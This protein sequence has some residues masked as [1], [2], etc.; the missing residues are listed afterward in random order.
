MGINPKGGFWNAV[1]NWHEIKDCCPYI[2]IEQGLLCFKVGEI[3]ERQ[4]ETRDHYH[5]LFM[6]HCVD[7]REIRRPN[8]FGKGVYMT[9]AVVDRVN[10]LGEDDGL[11]D[12]NNVVARLAYFES[13]Y[14][15]MIEK[16]RFDDTT[17]SISRS[18]A[19]QP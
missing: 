5:E 17:A 2:Q 9:I 4:S 14:S 15:Q 6:A 11:V 18:T 16:L 10:W 8:R 19:I 7:K 3:Y 13:V 1:L 12:M